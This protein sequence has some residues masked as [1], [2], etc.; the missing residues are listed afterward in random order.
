MKTGKIIIHQIATSDSTPDDNSYVP[1][2]FQK[3]TGR[4][5]GKLEPQDTDSTRLQELSLVN[6]THFGAIHYDIHLDMKLDYTMS[7]IFQKMSL[8]ELETLHK[9]CELERTQIL[10]SLALAVLKTLMQDICCQE[11]GQIFLTTKEM[12]YSIILV[13]KKC[14]LC[15]FSTT[16]DAITESQYSTKIKYTLLIHSPS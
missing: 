6:N 3:N 4:I 8:L 14:H 2:K 15:M 12:F 13:P 1:I 10:Q 7:R 11:T 16:Q 9:L 5:V